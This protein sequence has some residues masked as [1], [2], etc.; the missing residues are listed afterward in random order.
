M[1]RAIE[2]LKQGTQ[3]NKDCPIRKGNV[4]YMPSCSGRLIVV[5]DLHG[6]R[7]NF[8]RIV[9]YADLGNEP[10][11]ILVFQEIIHGGEQDEH[12]DCLSF[13][14]LFDIIRLKIKYPEQVHLIMGNH[15]MSVISNS[16]VLREGREMNNAMLRAI[17][18]YYEPDTELLVLALKQFLFSQPLAIRT[19]NRVWLSHSLPADSMVDGFDRDFLDRSLQISD[20]ARG[21]SAYCLT[22]GRRQSDS[23]VE[24]MCDLF[25]VDRFILGHQRQD[26]GYLILHERVLILASDHNHGCI[27][28]FELDKTLRNS[29]L[30]LSVIRIS[31]LI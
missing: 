28:A 9:S 3:L 16:E 25:D 10:D 26:A 21:K 12:G 30:E 13:T 20:L 7:R 11:N 2:L 8:E 15:D 4:I 14:L 24:K 1:Y 18:N 19:D 22:W 23:V 5:G 17:E 27:A 6:H 31:S 29:D